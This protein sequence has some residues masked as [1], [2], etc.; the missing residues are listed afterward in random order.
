VA[1]VS[2]TRSA[3]E[4]HGPFLE[5]LL[6]GEDSALNDSLR[7]ESVEFLWAPDVVTEHAFPTTAGAMLRDLYRRGRARGSLQGGP[8]WRL[9]FAARAAIEPA[10]ALPRA[11]RAG[12]PV[13]R[14]QLPVI[15]PLVVAGA[16]ATAAGIVRAGRPLSPAARRYGARQRKSLAERW[17]LGR[18]TQAGHAAD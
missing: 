14:R 18:E 12:S 8:L 9:A 15:A 16:V 4:R 3:L 6:G 13:P 1:G 11:S 17:Q 7:D 2:Y 5:S 10:I